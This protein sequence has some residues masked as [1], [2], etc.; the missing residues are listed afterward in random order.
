M[1]GVGVVFLIKLKNYRHMKRYMKPE[2]EITEV[3][4]KNMV[5]LSLSKGEAD[6]DYEG[7]GDVKVVNFADEEMEF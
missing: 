2:C 7:G 6:P 1:G 4:M 5:M 3:S